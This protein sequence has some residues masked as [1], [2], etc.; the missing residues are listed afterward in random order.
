MSRRLPL[1][2]V[3]C[4]ATLGGG[5]WLRK[6]AQARGSIAEVMLAAEEGDAATL[7]EAVARGAD[8]RGDP[9]SPLE[10]PLMA[11]VRGGHREAAQVLL[12][13]GA[14]VHIRDGYGRPVLGAAVGTGDPELV[15]LLVQ[16][17]A[18]VNARGSS[19]R[20]VLMRALGGARNVAVVRQVL[21]RLRG[22]GYPGDVSAEALFAASVRVDA[23]L[24]AL[25]LELGADVRARDDEGLTPLHQAAAG[26]D[27]A[28][29][30]M[31]L[32]AGADPNA[33]DRFGGT[34]LHCAVGRR[35][36]ECLRLLLRGGARADS[37]DA[38]GLTPLYYAAALGEPILAT[39][40]LQAGASPAVRDR[41]GRSP[42]DLVRRRLEREQAL[43]DLLRAPRLTSAGAAR[44]RAVPGRSAR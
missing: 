6:S 44:G 33:A 35:S 22:E 40:L 3:L 25:L 10:S 41:N 36:E 13:A 20:T 5:F 34:P 16:H 27:A 14:S 11:A 29:V 1:I 24:I 31:L 19:G 2:L 21:A 23:D 39:P 12:K 37:R 9:A 17:G 28:A 18:D 43:A 30:A 38:A 26:G 8:V 7:R 42:A 4:A 15:R 32:E